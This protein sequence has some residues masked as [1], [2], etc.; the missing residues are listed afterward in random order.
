MTDEEKKR[1]AIPIEPSPKTTYNTIKNYY[2][3]TTFS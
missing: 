3:K 2:E 1:G